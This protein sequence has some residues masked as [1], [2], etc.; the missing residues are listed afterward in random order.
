ME[1][2]FSD[3]QCS[4]RDALLEL[5]EKSSTPSDVRA[6]EPLGFDRS[7]WHTIA[8]MGIHSI[9]VDVDRGGGGGGF[10]ELAIAA[11]C[12]GR[13]LAPIP[14]I[15]SAAATTLLGSLPGSHLDSLI[16]RAISGEAIATLALHPAQD[17]V[18]QFVPAGAVA[19]VVVGLRGDELVAVELGKDRTPLPNLGSMPIAH[20]DLGT[21]HTVVLQ[22]GPQARETHHRA[23]RHWQLLTAHALTGLASRSLEIAVEYVQQRRAFGVLI[24]QFQSIQHRLADDTT[25]VEGSRLLAYEAAWAHDEALDTADTLSLMS[26]LFA[27][28]T[29]LRAA[30]DS[31]H[32]HG[33]YGFTLEYD[34]QL[35]LRRAKAWP[36]LAGDPRD[37]HTELARLMASD[38]GV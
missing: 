37:G 11:E 36:L 28:E 22:A 38:Q 21:S 33:G 6:A 2:D 10:L 24:A 35:Y 4:L 34:I 14:L 27:S 25:A 1:F 15:E 18:A 23:L 26:F 20:A 32:F 16:D 7:L 5:F 30:G 8:K 12:A 3:E 13:S 9:S 31:L 19:D 17:G 29:A